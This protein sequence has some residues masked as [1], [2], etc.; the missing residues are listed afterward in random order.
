M[1]SQLPGVHHQS[2]KRQMGTSDNQARDLLVNQKNL[3][4][5]LSQ[6]ISIEML[7]LT[8]LYF[9]ELKLCGSMDHAF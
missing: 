5:A 3:I 6:S 7:H 1:V 8:Q 9:S 4:F 2:C